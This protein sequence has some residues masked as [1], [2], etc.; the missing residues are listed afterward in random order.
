M[1]TDNPIRLRLSVPI[2]QPCPISSLKPNLFK[3]QPTE[4]GPVPILPGLGMIDEELVKD[5]H[6]ILVKPFWMFGKQPKEYD[7]NGRC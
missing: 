3:R 7:R 6:A 2:E 4:P 1:K 5:I